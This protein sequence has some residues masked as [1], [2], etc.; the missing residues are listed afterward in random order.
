MPF[1][2]PNNSAGGSGASAVQGQIQAIDRTNDIGDWI[3]LDGRLKS[4]LTTAQQ[5][6]ATSL[7]YGANLPDMRGR[8]PIGAGGTAAVTYQSTAGSTTIA[9]N[10]LPNVSPVLFPSLGLIIGTRGVASG[11]SYDVYSSS[12][13][14]GGSTTNISYN[15]QSVSSINGNVTQQPYLPPV[16]G[17][18]YFVWLGT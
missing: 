4:T 6:V 12:V 1:N 18:N 9:Q 13:N 8:L 14:D 16:R 2:F 3:L 15:A 10:R 17:V 5:A 11:N 7:G